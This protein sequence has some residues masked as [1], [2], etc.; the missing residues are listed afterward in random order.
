MRVKF[1]LTRPESDTETAIF[2]RAT[3][4]ASKSKIYTGESV[5]PKYWNPKTHR[6]KVTP[7]FRDASPMNARLNDIESII[8][9]CYRD[10]IKE[11]GNQPTPAELKQSAELALG[12]VKGQSMDFYA[13][14]RDFIQR[15]RAGQRLSPK[16]TIVSPVKA[17]HLGTTLNTLTSFDE[18]NKRH[19]DFAN[20]DLE[21]YE[22]FT[23]WMRKQ[24][25]AE[26]TV[27]SHIRQLKAV[28]NESVERGFNANT[29]FRSTRF[30][31]TSENVDNLALTDNDLAGL[32]E[33]DLSD[34]PHLD[35]VRDL[36]LIGCYTGLR[37]SDF[38]RLTAENIDGGFIEIEQQKTSAR[39]VIPVHPVV[40]A[41]VSKYD[42]ALPNAISNQKLNSYLKDICKKVESLKAMTS[43][44]R[45]QGGLKTTVNYHKWELVSTH[46]ARRSFATNAY[47]QGVPTITI[48]AITGHKTEKSF[49]KYIKVSPREHAK[50]M[51]K[52]WAEAPMKVVK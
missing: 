43:K 8:I 47:L 37:Y 38:S 1:Y 26:N 48:M 25:L 13:Y 44:T 41:I 20:I 28:L 5:K 36:F 12:R 52:I 9:D 7:A 14:F 31:A 49:L 22:D 3:Y 15:T 16:G 29:A 30:I 34:A 33:L 39:V 17:K 42:G 18:A 32:R 6:A 10:H 51:A 2:A 27:G 35:R 11:T 4:N 45:T 21:F 24:G 50:L 19:T 23:N 46:T 40:R